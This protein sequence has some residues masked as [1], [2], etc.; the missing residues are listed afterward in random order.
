MQI[1]DLLPPRSINTM[2]VSYRHAV[3]MTFSLT[4]DSYFWKREEDCKGGRRTQSIDDVFNVDWMNTSVL[5]KRVHWYENTSLKQWNDY[6]T[7][8]YRSC[9]VP[10]VQ[11]DYDW[12]D[13]ILTFG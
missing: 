13:K 3:V 9:S 10:T 5:S 2:I 12:R 1:S 7:L 4:L 6:C 8:L 11:G